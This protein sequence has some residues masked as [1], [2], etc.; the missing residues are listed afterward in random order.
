MILFWDSVELILERVILASVLRNFGIVFESFAFKPSSEAATKPALDLLLKAGR[1]TVDTVK[2][3]GRVQL[4]I[5]DGDVDVTSVKNN[6]RVLLGGGFPAGEAS[7]AKRPGSAD[8]E[9]ESGDKRAR[10]VSGDGSMPRKFSANARCDTR[11]CSG[12][13][14]FSS[15][16]PDS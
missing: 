4:A 11:S 16:I 13:T 10:S 6:V 7:S 1:A 3:K 2:A 15:L 5:S 8:T 12:H 14:A 9:S